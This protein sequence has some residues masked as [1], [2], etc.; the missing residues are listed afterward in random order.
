MKRV[1]LLSLV[2]VVLA[3]CGS[4]GETS[5]D[6]GVAD[7]G[8]QATIARIVAGLDF[9]AQNGCASCHCNAAQG[10]CNLDAPSLQGISAENLT[11]NLIHASTAEEDP[12]ISEPFD[13]H[14]LKLPKTTTDEIAALETFLDSLEPG[15]EIEDDS[16][17]GRGY[18]LY[19]SGDCIS[20][21]L[22]SAQGTAQG[23]I[24]QAIANAHPDVIYG[25]LSGA[26][27][28]HPLQ[29]AEPLDA[30][31]SVLGEYITDNPTV[32]ALTD[33][34][35]P[36]TD[37]E[38]YL[39]AHFLA[40]IAPPPTGGVVD[41]CQNRMDEICTVV[42]NGIGGYSKDGVP[43]TESLLYF[44]QD[45]TLHDVDGDSLLDLGIADWNNHR[46]RLVHL[47]AELEGVRDMIETIAGNS[48][49]AGSDTLNHP[50]D[51][52]FD[53][54]NGLYIS[55]WH[56][57]N[58]YRYPEGLVKGSD[59]DQL[60]GLC[61]LICP[62]DAD[63]PEPAIST[64]LGG[65]VSVSLH[66]DG[67]IFVS[68]STCV[69][70][71][72]LTITSSSSTLMRPAACP[73]SVHL[74]TQTAIET[75]AGIGSTAG[76]EGD[77]GPARLAKFN[78]TR[79]TSLPNFRIALEQGPDPER[80]YVTDSQ[81]NAIRYINIKA[82]PPTVHLLAGRAGTDGVGFVDGMGGDARFNYPTNVYVDAAGFVYVSDARNHAIRK[83]SREG[84]VET[85]AGTGRAGFNGDNIPAKEA[86]L[87][88]PN[89]VVVHPDGRVFISDTNNNRIRVI[90]P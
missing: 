19:V 85:I 86:Q 89:G 57:Q 88:N 52:A 39:L 38:R 40:F 35:P 73:S 75:L 81:N 82:N 21:H 8:D 22:M 53:T 2:L 5:A 67:R 20:C 79:G 10:G 14:P 44:P 76:Y 28:C 41:P 11:A 37:E 34:A 77:G 63:L 46:I 80:L 3:G 68:E 84:M 33:I 74:Y 42:G 31:C 18:A 61:A 69:R 23:G 49:V 43:A 4:K 51:L 78:S 47:D 54:E 60:A 66:P 59:R 48:K 16:L 45:I 83:I 36:N 24:G 50:T 25:A 6:A 27:V 55:G 64:F 65:P 62:P 13:P 58:I 15:A 30:N 26:V 1:V 87:N 32:T 72:T 12:T 17:I 71:R 70:I 56:N 90:R 9:Y 7:G 29:R